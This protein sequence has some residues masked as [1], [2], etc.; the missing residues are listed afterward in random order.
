MHDVVD[1]FIAADALRGPGEN[2]ARHFPAEHFV[3][4][5]AHRV[6]VRA[7]IHVH[8]ALLLR[9]HVVWRAHDEAG[10]GG[11][12]GF[13]RRF[14]Q[15]RQAKVRDLHMALGVHHDVGRL[16]VP[17]HDALPVRVGQRRADLPG[18][19]QRLLGI[20]PDLV[21]DLVQI[22][23]LD[24]FHDEE[25][26]ALRR[27]AEVMHGKDVRVVEPGHGPGLAH[28][29]VHEILAHADLQRQDLDRD[30]AVQRDLPR[31]VHR[32]HPAAPE[33][34]RHLVVR[35]KPRHVGDLRRDPAV[36]AGARHL[37][38][39]QPPREQ[40]A[41]MQA[42]QICRDRSFRSRRHVV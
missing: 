36:R 23:A 26:V 18:E 25:K 3:E 40:F 39:L 9:S 33:H 41:G 6:D 13:R 15:P 24:E 11:G 22:R 27:L 19:R 4:H 2:A 8:A 17:V 10:L 28:K 31:L 20:E 34:L 32:A 21:N 14:G 7:L 35:K 30:K 1:P 29:T 37:H 16:D 38:G 5:H 12:G 42:A